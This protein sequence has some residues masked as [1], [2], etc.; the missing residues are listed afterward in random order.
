MN[1]V[2]IRQLHTKRLNLFFTGWGMDENPC[3]NLFQ[4][5]EGDVCICYNYTDL[6]FDFTLLNAYSEIH[7]FAWSMGV[8]A[9]SATFQLIQDLFER[10]IALNGTMTPIDDQ[11][12]IPTDIFNGT[13]EHLNEQ[14]LERFNRRMCGTR[15]QKEWFEN[16]RPKRS[17]HE[18]KQELQAIKDHVQKI[19]VP[20]FNWDK[21]LIG[22]NDLIFPAQAQKK[23]WENVLQIITHDAHLPAFFLEPNHEDIIQTLYE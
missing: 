15:N 6:S 3:Y 21:V 4:N 18:L 1:T 23:A 10:K 20:N 7:L 17:V 14:T 22:E 11:R 5:I 2:F 16:H 12:G 19:K 9:A 13:L 8:W